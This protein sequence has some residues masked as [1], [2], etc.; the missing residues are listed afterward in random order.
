MTCEA[1]CGFFVDPVLSTIA[2]YC[3]VQY[4]PTSVMDI[5][6]TN[7]MEGGFDFERDV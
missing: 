7:Y 5:D 3:T 2:S 6:V 4:L 1:L